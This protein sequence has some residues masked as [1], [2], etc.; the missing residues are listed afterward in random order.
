MIGL[1]IHTYL[2]TK[3]KLFCKCKSS[4][5]KGLKDN[6]N[7]C[8][9][10]TGQ[11][12][13]KPM[14]PNKEAVKKAIQIGLML[15]CQINTH[16]KWQRKHYNWPDMPKGFQN[17]LS[18]PH[19]TPVGIK[20]EFMKINIDSMHLEEDPAS[21]TPETGCVNYNRSGI[22]LVEIVTN[23]DFSNSEEVINWLK[24]LIHNL[25]YLKAVDSNAGI[26]VDVNVNIPG[27][28]QRVE[29]KNISSLEDIK[30]AIDHELERHIKE[31]QDS[32]ETRRYDSS[33][34][35]TITMRTKEEAH[36]YR[37]ISDPDL[38][39]LNFS[40]QFIKEIKESLPE[41]P[42]IK[43]KKLIEKYNIDKEN[44][45]ILA[46]NIDIAEFFEKVAEKFDA[47][48]A[49]PWITINL[50]RL[51]NDH[52][53]NLDNIN[54]EVNHFITLL[55]LLKE[56]KITP[57][58]AKEILK[59][60]YPKSFM[61]SSIPE[62]ISEKDELEI[63]I[64]QSIEK[65]PKAVEDYKSGEQNALNFL[66]GYVMKLTQK[67]ADFKTAKELLIETLEKEN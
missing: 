27:K 59:Q 41:A 19:A 28:T 50:L 7:T 63:F 12:G 43:L 47:K 37:F 20:G 4:R 11:P 21:W 14:R 48:F 31:G 38:L 54:I 10:C 25:S 15:N 34:N 35:T 30:N 13:S 32:K 26:K 52:K 62:K 5:E 61:P 67:R 53:T 33:T 29:I 65:N 55:K 56:E 58:K 46:K 39:D 9:I 23:P 49:L 17:T 8:P 44:A 66:L 2:I 60:F 18:G 6:I 45:E 16:L 1:E 24:K 42:E 64:K 57:L 36:D 51:L 40:E 3:E 22:P